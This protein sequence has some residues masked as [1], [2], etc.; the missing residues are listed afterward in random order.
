VNQWA[1]DPLKVSANNFLAAV[2]SEIPVSLIATPRSQLKCACHR[3]WEK[4]ALNPDLA[5]FDQVPLTDDRGIQIEGVFVRGKDR[6][7]LREEMFMAADTPLLSFLETAD[8]V[9]FRFLLSDSDIS[10]M[11]T[12]SDVQKLPVYS[13]LFSLLIAVEMLLIDWVRKRCRNAPDEWFRIL[14][15]PQ[16]NKIEKDWQDA[17]SKN[18]AIDRI[19]CASFPNEIEAAKRLGLFEKDED[20]HAKFEQLKSLRNQVCHAFELAPNL[21]QALKLPCLVRNALEVIN[22]LHQKIEKQK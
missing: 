12:L 8:R 6:L 1:S 7:D 10:G 16:R 21:T 15:K 19:S 17:L 13:V 14:D 18:M 4:I 2:R 22:F 11:V 5:D 20:Q 3:Q 9:R